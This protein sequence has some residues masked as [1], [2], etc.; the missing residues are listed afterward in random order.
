[1][2]LNAMIRRLGKLESRIG[3]RQARA[4]LTAAEIEDIQRRVANEQKLDSESIRRIEAHGHIVGCN[5]IISA[6]GGT[7]WVKRY[8]GVDL[9]EL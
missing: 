9:D 3:R 4:P 5:M 7:Y 6:S 8:L 2:S 1:M